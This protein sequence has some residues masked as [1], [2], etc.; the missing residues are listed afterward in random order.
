MRFCLVFLVLLVTECIVASPPSYC[1]SLTKDDSGD[2]YENAV[3]FYFGL[4]DGELGDAQYEVWFQWNYET[5]GTNMYIDIE[6]NDDSAYDDV[7]PLLINQ[8]PVIGGF[9]FS[10]DNTGYFYRT[11][12]L[13]CSPDNQTFSWGPSYPDYRAAYDTDPEGSYEHLEVFEEWSAPR[14]KIF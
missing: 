9:N 14:G 2:A 3:E 12:N 10:Y 8:V 4:N 7:E 13:V 6:G 1:V 5:F 11:A